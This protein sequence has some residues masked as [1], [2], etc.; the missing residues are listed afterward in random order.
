MRPYLV[1]ATLVALLV[2]SATS[3]VGAPPPPP[4][5]DESTDA[6]WTGSTGTCEPLVGAPPSECEQG[7]CVGSELCAVDANPPTFTVCARTGCE[8]DCDCPA[9][10]TGT[11]TPI[12]STFADASLPTACYLA[13]EADAE[14]PSGMVCVNDRLCMFPI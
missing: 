3:C 13:C 6:T 4:A 14:C 2:G 9:P 11:A 1:E 5:D 8:R 12:C 7:V 10:P